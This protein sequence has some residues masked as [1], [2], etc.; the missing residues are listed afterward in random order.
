MESLNDI[1][2]RVP[3][4]SP[5]AT[6]SGSAPAPMCPTCR[7]IGFLR[8]NAPVGH[9]HFGRLMPCTCRQQAAYAP[10][11]PQPA[12][13]ALAGQT[14]ATFDPTVAGTA[15][16]FRICW[17]YAERPV[18]WL[19]L[20]GHYG[21]GKT[22]LAVA[23]AHQARACGLGTYFAVAP[24]LLDHLRATYAPSSAVSYD[25]TFE[26]IRSV[27][28]LVIDDLGAEV[29]T[30]WAGE[31]LYQLDSVLILLVKVRELK[32]KTATLSYIS[33]LDS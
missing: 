8:M 23:V 21:C 11:V 2:T 25:E 17:E 15:E 3:L 19:L 31:K 10:P 30:P 28:L 16:V 27:P 6:G 22:H 7:G 13:V 14:F 29:S 33:D 18:G 26:H 1:L 4:P 24:D 5:N 9:P 32:S 20:R 12:L